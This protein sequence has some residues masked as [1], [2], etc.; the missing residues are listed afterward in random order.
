MQL[1]SLLEIIGFNLFDIISI[2]IATNLVLN[3]LLILRMYMFQS[4]LH[5]DLRESTETTTTV[6]RM[7]VL[8]IGSLRNSLHYIFARITFKFLMAS[9]Q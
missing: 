2:I 8:H 6:E 5:V 1:V 9:L 3:V 7:L 4:N